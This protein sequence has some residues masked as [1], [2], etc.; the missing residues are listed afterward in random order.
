MPP[1]PSVTAEVRVHRTDTEGLAVRTKKRKRLTG[2]EQLAPTAAERRNQ[3]WSMDF[4]SGSLCSGRRF[5]VLNIVDDFTHESLGQIVDV[6]TSGER[7]TRFLDQLAALHAPTSR[8][9][10]ASSATNT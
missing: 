6:S 1:T 5:R 10:T 2:R 8:A 7:V 4:V 9:A 3:R